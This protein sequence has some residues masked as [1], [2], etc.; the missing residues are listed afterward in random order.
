MKSSGWQNEGLVRPIEGFDFIEF[1]DTTFETMR[2]YL[3]HNQ[4]SH[5]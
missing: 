3:I 5:T 1:A 2:Q 4:L